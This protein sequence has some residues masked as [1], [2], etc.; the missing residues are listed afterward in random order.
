MCGLFFNSL[1][2]FYRI[3]LLFAFEGSH[4]DLMNVP[5][6]EVQIR[7]SESS[8]YND[9]LTMVKVHTISLGNLSICRLLRM[10]I[11]NFSSKNLI[12]FILFSGIET[13]R[14]FR[15]DFLIK[16]SSLNLIPQKR[17][18]KR[19]IIIKRLLLK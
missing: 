5:F 11:G 19:K 6:D 7:I 18:E 13:D 3:M 8:I 4:H 10:T 12:E 16:V 14:I 2:C 1:H 17:K 15:G 9:H